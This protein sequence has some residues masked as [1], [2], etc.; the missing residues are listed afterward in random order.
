VR[1]YWFDDRIE[2]YNPGGP[3][4][5][6]TVENFGRPGVTDYRNPHLADAIKVLGPKLRSWRTQ[7]RKRLDHWPS[8]EFE[9]PTG[10]MQPLGYII[11]QHSVRLSRPVKAYDRWVNRMPGVYH[12]SV[13]GQSDRTMTPA[14]DPDCLA[15]LK[16]YRSLMPLA[17][18]ARKRVFKLTA[19]DALSRFSPRNRGWTDP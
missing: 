8:P 1:V 11:Q 7:W 15:T 16:H 6:V 14:A 9:L 10:E 2:I 18:E 12:Q 19:A 17:Q 3:Y 5:A 4:G 13:L